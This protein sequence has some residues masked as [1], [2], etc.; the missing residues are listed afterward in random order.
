MSWSIHLYLENQ[1]EGLI[2]TLELSK[3]QK[4]F[5]RDLKDLVRVRIKDV[6]DEVKGLVKEGET[7]SFAF[8]SVYEQL[9]KGVFSQYLMESEILE[10][11]RIL[12]TM[13]SDERE[14]FLKISPRFW[15]Q[16]SY[17]YKTLNQ[18]YQLPPQ[19]MD[20]DDGTYLPMDVFDNKPRLGHGLFFLLVD[21]ALRSLS[22]E[23]SG[24]LFD[25]TKKNL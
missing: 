5:L 15:I 12:S 11:A 21:A 3:S 24:W 20:I 16:G 18:P 23:N 10:A 25:G 8:E 13:S 14:S 4:N 22:E 1:Q 7:Q 19:E 6:F 9:R 2:S 17:K